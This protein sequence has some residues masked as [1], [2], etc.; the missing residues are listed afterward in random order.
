MPYWLAFVLTVAVSFIVGVVIERI[1]MRPIARRA[2]ARLGRRVRRPALIINALAG[3]IFD[4]IDQDFPT[5]FSG[6]PW[7][8][9]GYMSGA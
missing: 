3:W 4:Y 9:S 5:P 2:G 6:R 7:F 8:G 1:L